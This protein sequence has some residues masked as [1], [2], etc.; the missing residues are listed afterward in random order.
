MTSI[1]HYYRE[2]N[3]AFLDKRWKQGFEIFYMV[4]GES[5]DEVRFLKFTDYTPENH[6]KILGLMGAG[7][8]Q[9][10]FIHETDLIRYYR[11]VVFGTLHKNLEGDTR[12]IEKIRSIYQVTR[13]LLQEY[14]INIASSRILR[15]LKELMILLENSLSKGNLAFT[16]IFAVTEKDGQVYTHSANVGLYCA[17]LGS[18]LKMKPEAVGELGLGGVLFDVGKK[19]V[20]NEILSKKNELSEQEFKM[21]RRHPAAGKK[22][23][24]DMKCFSPNILR[25]SAEHHEKFN[26][27]GY[28]FGLA[29]DKISPHARLCSIMDVLNALTSE[30]PY[31]QPLNIINALNAMKNDMPGCFDQ[32]IFVNFIKTLSPRG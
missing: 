20:P 28:P 26:G 13:S 11:E 7:D 22:T 1:A 16:D 17:F 4:D 31:H 21:V 18:A 30:R 27:E 10:F 9:E 2:I 24:N 19:Q 8:C 14:F 25:M 12:S 5:E 6:E 29:G 32:R 23:L 15:N 3:P